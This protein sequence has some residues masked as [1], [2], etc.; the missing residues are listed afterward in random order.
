MNELAL[1]AGGG[2]GIL[3]GKLLGWST[4]CAVEFNSDARDVLLSRQRD[5]IL[6]PFPIWDDIRTF[7]GRPWRGHID[8]ATGGFPCQDVSPARSNSKSNGKQLGI[9]GKSSGLWTQMRR[10]VGEVQPKFVLI[11][12]SPQ[13]RTRGLSVVLRDLA[14]MGYDAKWGVLGGRQFGADH[15][16]ERIWIV[17]S[18]PYL[19]Q[20]KGGGLP[21]GI[22]QKDTNFSGSD[23]WESESGV[24]RVA[25]GLAGG[26]GK[27]L[28]I[29]GNG[30]IPA[31]VALA[32]SVLGPP[33]ELPFVLTS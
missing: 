28:R 11:E 3:G 31:V 23:W 8:I 18:N 15:V 5:G 20:C 24:E 33:S 13:L 30:Q 21:S 2:G 26:L 7:D 1:F 29:I 9:K 19:P 25:N 27:R 4:R 16:R 22:H 14:A 12:N 32:W 10:V 6:D 17:A